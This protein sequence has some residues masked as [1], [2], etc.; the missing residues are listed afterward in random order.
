[1]DGADL[2]AGSHAYGRS[3]LWVAAFF[4]RLEVA[5]RLLRRGAN[6]NARDAD[7]TTPLFVAAQEGHLTMV[8]L[9]INARADMDIP[10]SIGNT[11]LMIA[12]AHG[13]NI[14]AEAQG[15]TRIVKLLLDNGKH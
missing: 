5:E 14:V 8:E 3:A 6:V 2:N 4:N 13:F 7:G 9:L 11:P 10:S 12:A 1:M 15:Y